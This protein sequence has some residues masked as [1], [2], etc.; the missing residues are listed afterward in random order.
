MGRRRQAQY[1]QTQVDPCLKPLIRK[2]LGSAELPADFQRWLYETLRGRYGDQDI[3]EGSQHAAT[4]FESTMC[5]LESCVSR[6]AEIFSV[7]NPAAY[8]LAIESLSG[9]RSN[10]AELK[11]RY[12]KEHAQEQ[13]RIRA[14]E[15]ERKRRAAEEEAKKLRE[16]EEAQK[17]R[18]AEEAQKRR[19]AEE[20]QRLAKQRKA[21]E[22]TMSSSEHVRLFMS[23]ARGP[24]TT[25][26]ARKLKS[27]LEAQG[28][29]VWMVRVLHLPQSL[30][31][32]FLFAR[33]RK[34]S[35]LA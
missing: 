32:L 9:L 27:Y 11:A 20:A 33:T 29:A 22:Q 28:F 23:Y 24:E 31:K 21:A 6:M 25:S 16:A 17:R 4:D 30:E 13:A 5:T 35:L 3:G 18:E 8:K 19:E 10:A 34:G 15:E 7:L 1:L 12:G 14:E 2:C 26:F